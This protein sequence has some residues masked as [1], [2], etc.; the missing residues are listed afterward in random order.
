MVITLCSDG[1][2]RTAMPPCFASRSSAAQRNV[3]GER[4]LGIGVIRL[5]ARKALAAALKGSGPH[6]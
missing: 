1:E 3:D 2:I 4:L 6:R 5:E